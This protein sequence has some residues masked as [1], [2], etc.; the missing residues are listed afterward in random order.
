MNILIAADYRAPQSG[1]FIASLIALG[2]KLQKMVA[3]WCMYFP[4]KGT[5]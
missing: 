5:G 4:Q 2:R 1:N 3:M